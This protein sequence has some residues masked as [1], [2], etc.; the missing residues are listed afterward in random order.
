MPTYEYEC[1]NCGHHFETFQHMTEEPLKVCPQ[2]GKSIHRVINGGVGVI[3]KGSG[4]YINDSRHTSTTSTLGSAK[5]EEKAPAAETKAGAK[6]SSPVKTESKAPE[7][8]A[9]ETPAA[10]S[11]GPQK[12]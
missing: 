5:K 6:E 4:F 8:S 12:T 10:E 9:K 7:S 11:H 1:D 3:F 2:C